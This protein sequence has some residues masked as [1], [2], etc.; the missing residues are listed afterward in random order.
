MPGLFPDPV[1]APITVEPLSSKTIACAAAGVPFMPPIFTVIKILLE[2][3]DGVIDA[4]NPVTAAPVAVN[5]P[6]E[7]VTVVVV[8]NA[9][10]NVVL[11][12]CNTLPED[13]CTAE[14]LPAVTGNVT[15]AVPS[16]IVV[17]LLPF[18]R[19]DSGG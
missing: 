11:T 4:D 18:Q 15:P 16:I 17:I 12:T 6:P 2:E 19:H 13:A 10:V 9:V 14:A 8:E 3:L 5:K 1:P 7:A